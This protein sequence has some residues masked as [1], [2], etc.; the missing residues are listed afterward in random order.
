M[1]RADVHT[2]IGAYALDAV[3]EADR[4]AF[5]R[6]LARCDSC[7]EEVAGLRRT[8]LRL[9]E[10]AAVAPPRAVRERVL[11]EVRGTPQVR[12]AVPARPPARPAA[13]DAR[14]RVWL[15][16]AS[17]LA[18]L[19][20]GAGALAWAQYRAADAARTEAARIN[21]VVTD[22]GARLVQQ[23]LPGGGTATMVVAGSRAVLGGAGLPALPSDRTYQLW[24]IRGQRITSAGL[25]PAGSAGAGQ[26]SR[27]VTGVQAGDVLA[28]S[29]EPDGGSPQP[30]TTPVVTL[31]A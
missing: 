18:V 5:E 19:A 21:A 3:D 24:V 25:G 16:A 22:P 29:V 11:A 30:T 2:L 13:P 15:V 17:V 14:S 9:G 10:V 27:L 26:W 6:H 7:R 4:E 1:E 31:R 20:L 12:D 23:R 28:V 8:A